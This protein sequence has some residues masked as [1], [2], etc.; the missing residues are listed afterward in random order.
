MKNLIT[1]VVSIA[2]EKK[3]NSKNFLAFVENFY[4][5]NK[6]GDFDEYS[7]EDLFNAAQFG[8]EF[9]A[10]KKS[11]EAKVRVFNPKN[12]QLT[13]ID[14]VN[15]DMPFLVDSTVAYLDNHG[16]KVKNIIHPLYSTVRNNKG[17]LISIS[18]EKNS[19]KESV[20]QLH[21]EKVYS[22]SELKILQEKIENILAN[23]SLVVKDW[24]PMM[25]L[26]QSA[27]KQ[28]KNNKEVKEFISWIVGGN[29][30]FL[31]AQEFEIKQVS[32]GK[33]CLEEVDSGLGVFRSKQEEFKP[34]VVNSSPE[35]VWDSVANPYVI[36]I[37]KSRYRSRIHRITN[38]ER[39]RVQK[40]SAEGKVIGEYRFI[41]LF[42]SSAYNCSISQIPLI[43]N[44][45]AKV[46]AGSG[47]VEGSHNYKDLNST[48]ESYPRDEL[49]QISE[50]DLLKN[51]TGIVA[52][53]GRSQVRFFGRKDKF[54]RFVSCLIFTPR[55]RSNSE[56]RYKIKEYLEG[57]YKGEVT[58]SFVQVT[59]S[60]LSRLHLII[61]TENKIPKIDESEIEAEITRMTRNWS[62]DLVEAIK[63]KFGEEKYA[64]LFA[65]YQ[66]AFSIS[67]SNRFDANRA[68]IDVSR[69]ESCLEKNSALFDLYKSSD[70]LTKDVTELKIYSPQKEIILSEIMPVLESFGFNVIHEQTYTVNV[71]EQKIWIHYFRLNL[72]KAGEEF[73]EEI[74]NNFEKTVDLIWQGVTQVGFLNR[75]IV[76]ANL[77]WKSVYMLRA[78][79]KYLYQIGFRYDHK[80]IADVLVRYSNITKLLV[81]LFEEKFDP[82]SS[83]K[84]VAN[85]SAQIKEA[86]NRVS[87]VTDDAVIKKFFGVIT[88]TLRTNYYQAA[89]DCSFKGYLSFKL[90]CKQVPGLP[91]PVPYAEIFVCSPKVEGIHLRGGKVARGGLRWSDRQEDFRTEILGLVKAQ[92]TKNAVIVPVGSKGGFVLKRD[93]TGFTRDQ[94][95]QEGVECYKTFLRGLLDLTDNVVNKKI[96]H[97][98]DVVRYD[99]ADPY[100]VVAA[101]KGTATFSDIANGI[102]AEY[103]FWLGDAFASGGSVGY[104][105][106]KMGITAKGGWI[107]V[108]RHFREM[109]IDT[110]SQ[111]FTC[112][113]IG[114]LAGDVFGNGMLLSKHIK[115]VAA[116]NHMHIFLDPNPDA[117]KSFVERERM[118][119]LPRSSWMDYD[120]S[121]ISKGG[122]I[123]ERSAKSLKI[124]S[125]VKVIL[126]IEE[127][128]LAP[129]DLIKAILK[130]PVDL[131]WNGG[132]G[133]YV[134]STDESHQDVGDRAN[135]PLRINGNELRC[136]VIG[137]GGNLGFTQKGRIEF[138]LSGGRI[139]TDAMD[140]SAGVDC[141][142]HEVNIKIALI[143]AMRAKKL[144]IEERNKFLESMTDEV[145][146]LVLE[147]NR[148][149]TQAISIASS[150]GIKLLGEQSQ[151]LDR[152]EKTGLLKREIE[153]LPTRKEIDKRQNDHIS[154]TRPELCVMLAYAK[155]DIYNQILASD[156]VKDKYF[157]SELFSYF[158]KT[159]QEKF[160]DEVANHQLR[161]EIIA[162]QI[163]NF[164]VNRMGI[165]FISQLAQD[166]GFSVVDVVKNF[167]I[168]CDS[169]RI[170]EVWEE[171]EKLDGKVASHLQMQMF[172]SANKLLERSIQWLLRNQMKGDMSKV[173]GRFRKIADDLYSALPGV[174]AQASKESFERKIERYRLNNVDAKLA[175]RIAAMDPVASAFDIAEISASS[176]FDLK[177]IAKIYFAVGT[178]F[179]LKWLRS[180][181]SNLPVTNHWQRLAHKTILEDIYSYQMRI[182]KQIVDFSCEDKKLCEVNSVENW[183][184]TVDFLVER[185]DGFI[186]DLKTQA[187]PDLSVFVVSL[188]RLKPLVK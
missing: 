8:F 153:F 50:K 47:Y 95:Q 157:E 20:I 30:I 51:A 12:S 5:D 65:K 146:R 174:L 102:S 165:T 110:Q 173:V 169:F 67:Y 2:E 43:R 140:N 49:F 150:Q 57:V 154:M 104:D 92:Q 36:E 69:I 164:V 79:Y 116:F 68:A 168:A 176:N 96:E 184:G 170:R 106:K 71:S 147:D 103:N 134:K 37:L 58:D 120:Q 160:A 77:D 1:R 70:L 81:K 61:R 149:Q 66:K 53:C 125:E 80:Y 63:A 161:R 84:E 27:A 78:Y 137:E 94:L 76:V 185:F 142:D 122:G 97:P 113:G 60:N 186:S 166:T 25:E 152:L 91:L 121:K 22:D 13:F 159:M 86:M 90:D 54:S 39:I 33:Y 35:E 131:I 82:A 3:V 48:L 83:H 23:I 100:L 44:K 119:N 158:P 111:D 123:F 126:G 101:D 45:A 56:L 32:K 133:T 19:R 127:D 182:A 42:T 135:D 18:A 17:E 73:S 171:V 74:K 24:K 130:A 151:F 124:S 28:I 138:A 16:L 179:S 6:T 41:G 88:A 163:T 29:F 115:L 9:F 7:P 141:S 31:G 99:E 75:L 72:G 87:D 34:L 21:L 177:T 156:L 52:I 128:E 144:T 14:I 40:I 26:A 180:R 11:S 143:A 175:A 139:N 187:N 38:A 46:I 178:R 109:G 15:E 105:H 85:I 132:I 4:A 188:N 155:M 62:D 93:L 55:D 118:F 64:S 108:I 107:S 148:L 59:D 112:V 114:D 136:K 145:G 167:L 10:K 129:N 117:A 162:T 98:R 172:L 89:P 181:I 183:I